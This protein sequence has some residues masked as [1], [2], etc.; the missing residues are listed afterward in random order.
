MKKNVFYNL[1]KVIKRGIFYSFKIEIY[2]MFFDEKYTNTKK[3]KFLVSCL[4]VFIKTNFQQPRF[5]EII[6]KGK[7]KSYSQIYQDLFVLSMVKKK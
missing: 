7:Y 1:N 4:S 6:L 5:I 2:K 3:R